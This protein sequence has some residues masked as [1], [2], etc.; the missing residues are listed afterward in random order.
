MPA[1]YIP[2][3]AVPVFYYG[4]NKMKFKNPYGIE[5]EQPAFTKYNKDNQTNELVSPSFGGHITDVEL[6]VPEK[7]VSKDGKPYIQQ[8]LK[9]T[10]SSDVGKEIVQFNWRN[11]LTKNLVAKL[12]RVEDFTRIGFLLGA[13]QRTDL[14]KQPILTPSGL[15]IFDP[16]ISVRESGIKLE[17][18]IVRAGKNNADSGLVALP[19]RE[20]RHESGEGVTKNVNEAERNEQDYPI[21]S[22]AYLTKVDKIYTDAL[23]VIKAKV[24]AQ[25]GDIPQPIN[26]EEAGIPVEDLNPNIEG[27]NMPF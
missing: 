27:M 23:A 7:K 9:V 19:E 18:M 24:E 20:Y 5:V 25:R 16:W 11:E 14:N 2:T 10:F 21:F 6:E 17:P 1:N 12:L 4:V 3:S 22:K 13:S 8:R 26:E 15:P